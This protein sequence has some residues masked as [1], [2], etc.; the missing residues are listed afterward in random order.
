MYHD[1]WSS[2]EFVWRVV[3]INVFL[4]YKSQV[5]LKLFMGGGVGVVGSKYSKSFQK[6]VILGIL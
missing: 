4:L 6:P 3:N 1:F 5:I 2:A